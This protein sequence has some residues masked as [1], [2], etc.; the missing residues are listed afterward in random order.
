MGGGMCHRRDY[1]FLAICVNHHSESVFKQLKR[2]RMYT[3]D[4]L[5]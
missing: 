5:Q 2:W 3:L 1:L 4:I